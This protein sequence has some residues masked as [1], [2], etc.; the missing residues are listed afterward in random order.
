MQAHATVDFE[1]IFLRAPVGMCVS[2]HRII[3]ACNDAL[4]AMFG[5]RRDGLEGQSF[6]V[7]YP[8]ADEFLRTGA[9]IVPIMT[10]RGHYSDERIMRRAGGELF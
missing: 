3:Q 1:T 6:Q 2:H 9:R 10:A 7:L 4:A 5:Y 8:S